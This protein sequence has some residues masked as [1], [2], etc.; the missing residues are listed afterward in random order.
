VETPVSTMTIK[1]LK[2]KALK[3]RTEWACWRAGQLF[4]SSVGQ[5]VSHHL[6]INLVTHLDLYVVY[7]HINF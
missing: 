1:G 5:L 7:T 2:L 6:A 3:L 4:S